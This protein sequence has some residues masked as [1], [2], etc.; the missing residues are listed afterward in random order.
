MKIN[1]L[2]IDDNPDFISQAKNEIAHWCRS[3]DCLVSFCK[4]NYIAYNE[5]LN[6]IDIIFLD[7]DLQTSQ[8]GISIAHKLR[9]ASYTG[10]IVFITSFKEYVF[11]AYKVD[12]LDYLV[13]PLSQK[14]LD[15]CLT[16]AYVNGQKKYFIYRKRDEISQIRN[17][18]ILYFQSNGHKS[19]AILESGKIISIPMSFKSLESNLSE[20]F[21]RCHRTIW[22]N[23]NKISSLNNKEILLSTGEHLPVG[24]IYIESLKLQYMNWYSS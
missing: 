2:I 22:V 21:A 24:A 19:E 23:I 13:K 10:I 6:N 9:Q 17:D 12:A 8:N 16:R 1:C 7:I 3:K 15:F 14:K 5:S 18:K 4:D 20:C 11:D